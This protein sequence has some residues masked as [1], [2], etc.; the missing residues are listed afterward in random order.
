MLVTCSKRMGIE[1]LNKLRKR[2]EVWVDAENGHRY[3]VENA[4]NKDVNG[5]NVLCVMNQRL[6]ILWCC[7]SSFGNQCKLIGFA[8]G[9]IYLP[10]K[11][12][13]GIVRTGG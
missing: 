2:G 11:R 3:R 7:D 5:S 13:F 1:I 8:E 12:V 10:R 6:R 9:T 4:E